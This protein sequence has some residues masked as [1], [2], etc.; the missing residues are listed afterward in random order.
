MIRIIKFVI[1][2]FFWICVFI[3]SFFDSRFY[4]KDDII[5]ILLV[6]VFEDY[7]VGILFVMI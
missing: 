2:K 3:I 5:F 1:F 7:F 4:L 6:Y